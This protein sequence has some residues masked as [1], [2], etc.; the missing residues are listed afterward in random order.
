MATLE[1]RLKLIETKEQQLKEQK[2]KLLKQHSEQER[3]E[4]T[5]RLIQ[6][7]ALAET[8]F[9]CIDLTEEDTKNLFIK[10]SE[11]QEV[12]NIL[13]VFKIKAD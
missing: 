12:K 13:P 9:N 3:K 10:I 6:K 11:L 4:R 2:R 8:Y 7:G 5:R 1:E